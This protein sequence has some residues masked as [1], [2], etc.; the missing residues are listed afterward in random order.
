M[1]IAARLARRVRRHSNGVTAP[2][3][4]VAAGRCAAC[5]VVGVIGFVTVVSFILHEY[6]RTYS[7]FQLDRPFLIHGEVRPVQLEF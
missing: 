5:T 2:G 7:K 6:V 1:Y 3:L 4:V